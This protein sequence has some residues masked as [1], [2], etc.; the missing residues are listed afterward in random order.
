LL[1]L[2][3]IFTQPM[4]VKLQI[5]YFVDKHASAIPADVPQTAVDDDDVRCVIKD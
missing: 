3:P 4:T 2:M 5:N 1:M